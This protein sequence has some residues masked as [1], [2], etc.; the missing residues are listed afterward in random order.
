MA[1][2]GGEGELGCSDVPGWEHEDYTNSFTG[3]RK[4]TPESRT[5]GS[6]KKGSKK[7][8]RAENTDIEYDLPKKGAS[9]EEDDG[10]DDD[11]VDED[12]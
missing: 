10:T 7:S 3:V 4:S 8:K 12:E 5:A 1:R 11:G 2:S 9:V 6:V